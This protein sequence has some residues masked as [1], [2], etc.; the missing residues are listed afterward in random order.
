MADMHMPRCTHVRH[1]KYV[2]GGVVGLSPILS[3]CHPFYMATRAAY[4]RAAGPPTPPLSTL[5]YLLRLYNPDTF[6]DSSNHHVAP[7]MPAVDTNHHA[8][9]LHAYVLGLE[10]G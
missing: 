7:F 3:G 9:T 5:Y 1:L 10:A 2:F 8:I 4:V 6:L